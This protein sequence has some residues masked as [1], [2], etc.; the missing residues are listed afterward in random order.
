MNFI[1]S[2][3]RRQFS[4]AVLKSPSSGVLTLERN[5]PCLAHSKIS[6]M[7]QRE[8]SNFLRQWKKRLSLATISFWGSIVEVSENPPRVLLF[9]WVELEGS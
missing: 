8:I 1:A 5:L 6:R 9:E 7:V 3:D 2:Q 4:E